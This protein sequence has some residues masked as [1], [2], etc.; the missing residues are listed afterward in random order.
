MVEI[1][2]YNSSNQP[3]KIKKRLRLQKQVAL[4]CLGAYTF[5]VFNFLIGVF[6]EP[7]IANYEYSI[8]HYNVSSRG[9]SKHSS[10]VSDIEIYTDKGHFRCTQK[11]PD[12]FEEAM[13]LKLW[14]TPFY[15]T[16]LKFQL[17]KP[18][19]DIYWSVVNIYIVFSF[20]PILGLLT[21]IL[22]LTV[23]ND[24]AEHYGFQLSIFSAIMLVF[25]CL[26]LGMV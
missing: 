2:Y 10:D 19:E 13:Q 24:F 20:F 5:L 18:D 16:T 6:S 1:A 11:V 23:K 25:S 12:E 26:M 4:A 14:Q 17:Q 9:S 3:V 21:A 15:N 7:V 8:N 22:C